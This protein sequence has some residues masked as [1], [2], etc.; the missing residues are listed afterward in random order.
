MRIMVLMMSL[1]LET[2]LAPYVSFIYLHKFY[3][4]YHAHQIQLTWCEAMLKCD[5]DKF[6]L[7]GHLGGNHRLQ[8]QN[9]RKRR[10]LSHH[11]LKE[12][13]KPLSLIL[14]KR[15][16][17]SVGIEVDHGRPNLSIE[18]KVGHG[19]SRTMAGSKQNSNVM[20][21]WFRARMAVVGSISELEWLSQA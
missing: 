20:G 7:N 19:G 11:A 5:I 8:N 10:I 2:L 13:I 4:Q 1:F 21:L 12:A 17:F 6:F 3:N 18:I 9:K 15:L 16:H 14:F